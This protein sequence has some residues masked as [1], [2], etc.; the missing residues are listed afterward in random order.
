[1][2][3]FLMFLSCGSILAACDVTKTDFPVRTEAVRAEVEELSTNVA[4]VQ[5]TADNIEAFDT[6]RN[7][8]GSRG[9]MPSG[10]WV[11]RVGV[12]DVPVSYTHLDVYKRQAE[13]LLDPLASLDRQSIS[14]VPRRAAVDS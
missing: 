13:G 12:G 5:L 10:T 2:R 4:I 1:M 3:Y 9:T 6:P 11:Y 8:D 7:L 14:F